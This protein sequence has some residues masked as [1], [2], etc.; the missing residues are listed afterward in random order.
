MEKNTCDI[1]KPMVSNDFDCYKII[2]VA[3]MFLEESVSEI[4]YQ[5]VCD[6]ARDVCSAKY[7][8]LNLYEDDG[9][10][11][12]SVAVSGVGGFASKASKILGFNVENR[13]WGDDPIKAEKIAE[14][15]ITKF[16]TLKDL[17][18]DT[19]PKSLVLIIEKTFNLGVTYV[20]KIQKKS[21]MIG[22]FT[23]IYEQGKDIENEGLMELYT[24]LVGMLISRKK[25]AED[26]RKSSEQYML[27]VE[28]SRD[29]IWDW[30]IENNSVFLSKRWK[31][32]VGYS[33]DELENKLGVFEGMLHPDDRE[34][35]DKYMKHY[36]KGEFKHYDIEF[37]MKHKD[38]TYRWIMARG[39]ALYDKK[40]IPFRMAGS[41]TDIT[42]KKEMEKKLEALAATDDLTGLW[43][44]RY[45]FNIGE[46]E[47]RRAIRYKAKLSMIMI[48]IDHFKVINDTFGHAAGDVVLKGVSDIFTHGLR[49]VD[50][51]ARIGGEE[52]AILMPNTDVAGA[53][54]VAERLRKN[55][56]MLNFEYEQQNIKIT[57]SLGV[58]ECCGKSTIDEMLKRSDEALYRAKNFGRNCVKVCNSKYKVIK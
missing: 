44:R 9:Q 29:G 38:G 41:H 27:A 57:V 11:F 10:T 6:T 13:K 5:K 46:Q 18:G 47:C 16:K 40:G 45:F 23:L 7:V 31:E 12:S 30:D 39:E 43:N 28:G 19:I 17:S 51:A 49:D 24:Q 58:T 26:L 34:R 37:R 33:E 14:K 22:D 2:G 3:K 42:E 15:T 21:K 55:I 36:L 25:A 4:S 32:I 53:M 1:Q 56:K 52:F 54:V 20:A 8:I 48:D 35:V 50:L